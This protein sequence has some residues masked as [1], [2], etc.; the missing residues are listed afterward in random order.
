MSMRRIAVLA[1]LLAGVGCAPRRVVYTD[2]EVP[3]ASPLEMAEGGVPGLE[4]NDPPDRVVRLNY[5]AGAVSRQ[6]AGLDE[7]APAVV[8]QP[9]G[10]GDSLWVAPEGRA[11][12]HA[13]PTG[14]RLAQGTGLD[15]LRLDNRMLQL[16]LP[17]GSMEVR[18]LPGRDADSVE[19]DTPTGAV[20]FNR[21]GEYRVDVDPDAAADR[22]TVRSGQA[23]VTAA[24][25]TVP[26]LAG[27]ALELSGGDSPKYDVVQARDPDGF[28]QWCTGR[29]NR[30]DRSESALYTGRSMIGYEDLDGQGTWQMNPTYGTAWVPRVP[31]GWA[32]YR[33]GHWVWAEPHGWTWVDDAPWGFAPTHYGRWAYVDNSWMW[34][35][36]ADGMRMPTPVYAPAVVAFAGGPGFRGKASAG[37][38]VAW[39]PLGPR[40]PYLPAYPASAAYVRGLNAANLAPG[41]GPVGLAATV[42]ANQAVPGALTVV[43]QGV[44]TGA[45]PVAAAMLTVKGPAQGWHVGSAPALVPRRESVLASLPG[46]PAPSRPPAGDASRPLMV[47]NRLPLA[48]V[49]FDAR[50]RALAAGQ[51]RPLAF[52]ALANLR[53]Q[54]PGLRAFPARLAGPVRSGA[55]LVPARPGLNPGRP[56]G[57]RPFSAPGGALGRPGQT[58]GS[59][60]GGLGQPQQ[61]RNLPMA[62][63]A[64]QGRQGLQGGPGQPGGPGQQGRLS[65]QGRPSQ[66]VRPN[67]P[68]DPGQQGRPGQPGGAN[69]GNGARRAPVRRQGPAR[70]QPRQ[71][72]AV[73]RREP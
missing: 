50:Q 62:G 44:F 28:E 26:V 48:P 21:P 46:G 43:P 2:D 20:Q 7:W 4:Q 60:A 30:E 52:A 12:L 56:V 9:L 31:A 71:G 19:V 68:R 41:A 69:R 45:Q 34:L 24:G 65:Q 14:V 11:E 8:N 27:S 40:E 15:V 1:V 51:G 32:P 63:P 3:M 29:D 49:P 36:H 38:G 37:G 42:H 33:N 6:P 64:Q 55:T 5:T 70:P 13:G 16:G 67:Q 17:R 58:L 39:F 61:G 72:G 47:R 54:G 35:P 53:A 22:I 25:V 73:P 66:Q 57:S 10:T 59:G 23:E 18:I